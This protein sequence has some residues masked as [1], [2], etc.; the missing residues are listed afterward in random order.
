MV[1]VPTGCYSSTALSKLFSSD[2][3]YMNLDANA[4]QASKLNKSEEPSF[5]EMKILIIKPMRALISQIYFW[6]RTLHATD[7]ISVC[8]M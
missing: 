7:S 6:N 2:K 4:S 5:T 8:N 1:S 3:P